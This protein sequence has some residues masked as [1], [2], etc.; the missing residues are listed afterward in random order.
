MSRIRIFCA[1]AAALLILTAVPAAGGEI[2]RDFNESFEVE[3]G[4]ALR[5]RYGDGDVTITPW[6]K[7][8]IEITVHYHAE[9]KGFGDDSDHDFTVEFEEKNGVLEVTG[10]ESRSGF[11]GLQVYILRE[12]TYTISAPRYIELDLN[13][14]DGN[15]DIEKWVGQ[16]EINLDDGDINLY[17]CNPD[18]TK[19]RAADG[20]ISLDGHSGSV[21]IVADDGRIDIN[22]GKFTDCRIQAEDGDI[23][24]RD[25]EG[26]FYI[27]VDD[28]DIE[29]LRIKTNVMDLKGQDGDI[30]IELL[31]TGKLDLEIRT[32]DGGID[33]SLQSGISA[34]FSID[35]DDGRIRTDLP[36]AKNVQSGNSWM[37]G[38]LGKGA[39][40][41]RIRTGDGSVMLREIR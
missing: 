7:D 9:R 32:D 11:M 24:I 27:E 13:G 20:D 29:L 25:S 33:L 35:V 38:K 8:I 34:S 40:N 6:D 41:I 1:A 12:Y 26:D 19:I 39:G 21:D 14:D 28:S 3:R 18:R 23:R 10:K 36:S 2:E 4:W 5:L 15:I 16:I 22:R 17:E 31:K 37:S 30:D